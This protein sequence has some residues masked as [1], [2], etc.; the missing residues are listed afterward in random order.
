M[1]PHWPKAA[2]MLLDAEDDILV[3]KT[4]PE[5]HQRSIHSTNPLERLNREIRRRTNVVGVFP[6]RPSILRLTGSL[7]LEQDEDWRAGRR[8]FSKK[9][10]DALLEPD[11]DPHTA[12]ATLFVEPLIKLE[13]QE[14]QNLHS[15]SDKRSDN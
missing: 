9:S 7:L 3:Y 10:M 1:R 6:D 14:E 15:S 8:Y 2:E 5:R 12:T 13:V 4:F 11:Q